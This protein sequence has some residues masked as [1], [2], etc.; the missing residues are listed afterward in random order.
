MLNKP[1][2]QVRTHTILEITRGLAVY[3]EQDVLTG[4]IPLTNYNGGEGLTILFAAGND[5]PNSDTI[6][7]GTARML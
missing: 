6:G 7:S 5:G 4:Q 2:M 1:T 3:S